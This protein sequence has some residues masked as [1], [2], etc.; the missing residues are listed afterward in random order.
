MNRIMCIA[1]PGKVIELNGKK[2]LVQ[3]QD[4]IRQAMVAQEKVKVGSYVL[5]QMGLI[6]EV[7]SQ[8]QAKEAEKAWK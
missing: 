8:S 6:I 7:L 4:E 1:A 5:V 3:Y 2:A